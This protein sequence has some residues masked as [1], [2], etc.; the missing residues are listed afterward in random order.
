MGKSFKLNQIS[1]G[2]IQI[3]GEV[4]GFAVRRYSKNIHSWKISIK[5]IHDKSLYKVTTADS[6][7]TIHTLKDIKARIGRIVNV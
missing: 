5:W 2:W 1:D 6:D 3:Y 4:N 7:E